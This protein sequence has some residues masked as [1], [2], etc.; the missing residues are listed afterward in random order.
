MTTKRQQIFFS[1]FLIRA[2]FFGIGFSRIIDLALQDAWISAILGTIIGSLFVFAI[3]KFMDLKKGKSL[4]EFLNEYKFVGK[5]L[6]LF[7]ILL[8]VFII[9][10]GITMLINFKTSFFLLNTPNFFIS[11]PAILIVLYVISKGLSTILKINEIIFYLTSTVSILVI[12]TLST[13][14]NINHFL[15]ILTTSFKNLIFSSIVF[16]VY[17]SVPL[18]FLT[19]LKNDGKGLLKMYWLTCLS[20]IL[21]FSVIL[22]VFGPTLADIYRYPEMIVLKRIKIFSFIEKIESIISTIRLFDNYALVVISSYTIKGLINNPKASKLFMPIIMAIIFFVTSFV[23]T[24]N[25]INVLRNYYLTFY[26]YLSGIIIGLAL[27]IMAIKKRHK[28]YIQREI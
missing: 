1:F 10:E 21:S 15:P 18:L 19:N 27:L 14:C 13:Y 20:L 12:I 26:V 16:A 7:I 23:I 17:S 9:T 5:V 4:N 2:T 11:L 22:G 6:K 3:A 28:P 8:A 25:Y 24:N